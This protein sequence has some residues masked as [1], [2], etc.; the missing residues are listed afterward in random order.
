MLWNIFIYELKHW[1]KQPSTYIFGTLFFVFGFAAMTISGDILGEKTVLEGSNAF[2]NS[3]FRIISYFYDLNLFI[4]F[5]IPIFIGGA[6]FR[7]YSSNAFMV[8]YSFP[9][10]KFD[11]FLGKFL[12]GFFI[13]SVILFLIG[14]GLFHGSL[15]PGLNPLLMGSNSILSYIQPYFLVVLPNAIFI[16]MLV[17]SVVLLSRNSYAG[18]ITVLLLYGLR[19]IILFVLG[20]PDNEFLV[21]LL[22]PFGQAAV[23]DSIRNWSIIEVNTSIVPPN[24]LLFYNRLIWIGISSIVFIISY[25]RFSLSQ[26][27]YSF[28]FV[29]RGSKKSTSEKRKELTAL[30][31]AITPVASDFSFFA[32]FVSTW[33]I[34]VYQFKSIVRSKAFL[35]ILVGSF[36]FMF[37]LLGQVNPQYTTRIQPLTQVMLL[38]P[39]LFY[40][41]VVMIIT[42]LYAGILIHRDR[43]ARMDQLVDA[44]AIPNWSLLVSKFL[45]LL[46][47]QIV[48]LSVIM[49]VGIC[50]QAW[51]GYFHFEIPL[52][53]FRIYGILFITLAIW[54]MMSIFV[55]TIVPNLYIGFFLLIMFAMGLS[56]LDSVGIKL[57]IFKFNSAPFTEY[58]DLSGFGD[59]LPA[60]LIHKFYWILFGSLLLIVSYLFWERGASNSI[61]ERFNTSLARLSKTIVFGF[62]LLMMGFIGTGFAIYTK[63]YPAKPTISTEELDRYKVEAEKKYSRYENLTQPR[64]SGVNM[65]MN[66]YPSKRNYS[67]SGELF[68]V[69]KSNSPIDTLLLSYSEGNK[70]SY[71]FNRNSNIIFEDSILHFDGHILNESLT[72]GDT[73]I[74]YYEAFNT[75]S[76]LFQT[77]SQVNKNGTFFLADIP[78][79][80][81]PEFELSNET[82]R[83]SY[84][85]PQQNEI[86]FHPNDS[87]ANKNSYVGEN[88]DK[89]DFE[90]I[91]STSSDQVAL[92][93]GKLINKWMNQNR[94]YFHYK[95]DAKIRNGIVFN[96]GK[97]EVLKDSLNGI[98][99]EIYHHQTHTFNLDRMM[100]AMKATLEY[101]TKNFGDYPSQQLRI[102]EFPKQYGQFAQSFASTI[103]FSEFAGFISK[104]DESENRFDDVFRLTAHEMAHQWWGH[105]IIPAEAL[106][107]RMISEGLAEYTAL[108]VLEQEYGKE[109]KELY[110]GFI[111]NNYLDQHRRA[112]NES[113][114][115]LVEPNESYVHYAKGLIAFNSLNEY[116]GEEAFNS[117]LKNFFTNFK[118]IEAPYPTSI[119]LVNEIK[120]VT[121]DSLQYLVHDFLETVTLYDNSIVNSQIKELKNG[122]FEIEIEF[123][124]SK[125]RN[126]NSNEKVF[127]EDGST[128]TYKTGKGEI[129]QSLPLNDYIEIGF[130]GK[131]KQLIKLKKYPVSSINNTLTISLDKEPSNVLL[132]PFKLLIEENIK[133]N[134]IAL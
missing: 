107:N 132:D 89:F 122:K 113:P 24:K 62:L 118:S 87:L 119:D 37:L 129:I 17:F 117:A 92:A 27:I 13:T 99:L 65:Y 78:H 106:G 134:E 26:N 81:Y 73:L 69:N 16:S 38:V 40:S 86:N 124:I 52:Y 14:L 130:F 10:K 120:K 57:D 30:R 36:I 133:N 59:T 25:Q 5:L 85:L 34:S 88:V 79:F 28:K 8:L 7:D 128:L 66:L 77:N 50:I 74:L 109:K 97:F 104:Q 98:S 47:L 55:Q 29:H 68:F 2:A 49:F 103:P 35:S 100:N 125:F 4:L 94:A 110:L 19:R 53:L 93:P 39:A 44:C 123:N 56:G 1:F 101:S 45:T 54:A 15:L 48:L 115:Y 46:K 12:S 20:G 63:V 3:S 75:P 51:K 90:A 71:S 102:V 6:V 9:I 131:D 67:T 64:L 105:Q 11:Y 80:R 112:R 61:K 42:F 84:G 111:R 82:K 121:P 58:S 21:A 83:S 126:H 96:S 32:Q 70:L 76:T 95:S 116:L 31:T 114:L 18:F 33:N 72:S 108:K 22:D 23:F 91:V 41:F 127:E 60:Y 43:R